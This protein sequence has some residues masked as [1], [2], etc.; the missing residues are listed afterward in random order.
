MCYP[1]D[2]IKK[3]KGGIIMLKFQPISVSTR[4][5]VNHTKT[6]DSEIITNLQFFKRP[7]SSSARKLIV[8]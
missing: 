1:N 3:I 2:R 4:D 6:T 8:K 7:F 5:N